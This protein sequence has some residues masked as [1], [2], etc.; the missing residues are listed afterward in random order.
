MR[1]NVNPF[2]I[3]HSSFIFS[4]DHISLAMTRDTGD[5][6]AGASVGAQIIAKGGHMLGY[7]TQH[8]N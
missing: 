6:G 5:A 1:H 3:L 4:F 8:F 2:I 7:P